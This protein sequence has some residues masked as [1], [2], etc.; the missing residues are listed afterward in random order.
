MHNLPSPSTEALQH[1]QHLFNFLGDACQKQGG[2]LSFAD[3]MKIALYAPG[4]GYYSAGMHKFGKTGDFVT[5]PEISPLFSKCIGAQCAQILEGLNTDPAY[6]LEIGAGS[7][8]MA[9]EI[10]HYLAEKH[11]LPRNYWILEVSADLRERQQSYLRQHCSKHFGRII[12]LDT[13]PPKPF[14]G[15]IL[16]N[17]VI[18]AMPVHLFQIGEQG[19]VLEGQV[20]HLDNTLDLSF[21][22]PIT[23]ALP[24]AVQNLQKALP[25]PLSPGYTSEIN[26]G[27]APWL[28]S[29]S[30]CLEKGVML[31]LDYG[32]PRHEYYHLSRTMGTLMCHYRH[33]AHSNPLEYIGLQDITAHVDFTALALAAKSCG[34]E[35]SGF[36]HQAAFLLANGLLN[37]AQQ[38]DPSTR[39]QL[40]RSAQVQKLTQPHEM[41]ELFK[42]LAL[43]KNFDSPLQGFDMVDHR[44][45]LDG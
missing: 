25:E 32:F 38:N 17:E 5:A 30:P 45:R 34:L 27:L 22:T 19:E 33:H 21:S 39:Q 26:L 28:A 1:Q 36:T 8:R 44:H 11:R 14:T 4:L 18:D 43:N 31:F 24:K 9:S 15:I 37:F 35:L 16:A 29:L 20:Q 3:F 2:K 23:E 13:L 12:W 7:G 6:I 41:G 40:E 42:V 10:L